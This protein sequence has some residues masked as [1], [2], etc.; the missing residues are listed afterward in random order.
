MNKN[1]TS[2]SKRVHFTYV[3]KETKFIKELHKNSNVNISYKTYNNIPRLL[4][5]NQQEY[6][7]KYSWKDKY[8]LT[9]PDR[10]KRYLGQTG[11]AFRT[12]L[13]EHFQ[14]RK[15]QNKNPKF[16]QHHQEGHHSFG[17][18]EDDIEI[19]KFVMKGL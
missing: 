10:G 17:A 12:R 6:T 1:E 7:N 15:H 14:S 4:A 3:G 13:K 8:A 19:L 16:S 5:Y 18:L 2:T 9:R 11:R